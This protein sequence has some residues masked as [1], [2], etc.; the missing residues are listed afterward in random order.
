MKVKKLK[1]FT[2]EYIVF[3]IAQEINNIFH[4]LNFKK[5]KLR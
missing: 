2:L 5:A 4:L 1:K 3:C